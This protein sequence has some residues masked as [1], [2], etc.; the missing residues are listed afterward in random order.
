MATYSKLAADAFKKMG[1]G[2]GVILTEFDPENGE[3]PDSAI[4][5]ATTGDLTFNPNITTT[6]LAED[7]NNAKPGTMQLTQFANSDPHL[8]GTLLTVD[9]SS[10][11]K[12]I[13]TASVT[14]SGGVT[15]VTPGKNFTSKDFFSV[16]LVTDYSTLLNAAGATVSGYFA[17]H[18]KNCMNM[19]GLQTTTTKDGKTQWPFDFKAFYDLNDYDAE[20]Y[21]I[22]IK[23]D[24]SASG[25]GAGG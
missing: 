7:V 19:T 13:P 22:Y 1:F 23:A 16:W 17:I 25:E 21:E 9:E 20:P 12:L 5:G 11:G 24:T 8:T 18:M 15:K 4:I 2:A 14:T 6:D 3:V 10:I